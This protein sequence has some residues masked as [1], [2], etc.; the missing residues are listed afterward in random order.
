MAL[1]Y[2]LAELWNGPS[3]R[4]W[5]VA[6]VAAGLA[7]LAPFGL[8]LFHR[9]LCGLVR[10]TDVNPGSAACPTTIPDLD[11]T[12]R[13]IAIAVVVGIGV[14]LLV[15]VLLSFGDDAETEEGSSSRTRNL[16]VTAAVVA[17][18]VSVAFALA[19]TLFTNVGVIH[20]HTFPVEPIALVVTIA[21]LPV[22]AFVATARDSRRFVV[23]AL[24]AIG[25]WFV[26]WYP[27]VAALP[28][29]AALHNAYQGFLPTY[30]YPFQFPVATGDRIAP[31]LVDIRVAEL[32]IALIVTVLAV[33]Y[34]AWVWRIAL[35]E[36]RRDEA[37][38]GGADPPAA[39]G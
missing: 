17:A 16:L 27:N 8:W 5:V 19:S 26:L 39:A 7:I 34:S 10:V 37:A 2:F 11:I 23:G 1:A 30:V 6:R 4:T 20:L 18:G 24:A 36:R 31:S 14:L 13:A 21:L 29:P 15:R 35:A 12:P 38:W 33:G 28:L 22:A 32:L 25:F 9:P 3:W